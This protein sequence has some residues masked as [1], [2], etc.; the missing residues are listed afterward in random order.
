MD[1]ESLCQRAVAG[2]QEALGSLIMLHQSRLKRMIAVRIEPGLAARVD[3]SDVIQE[4]SL[5][6]ARRIEEYGN[7]QKVPF[8]VWM[9]FLAKQKLAEL[10]RRHVYAQSRDVRREVRLNPQVQ[11][12]SSRM[13]TEFLLADHTSPS[14]VLGNAEHKQLIS[15]T[16]DSLEP[17][18]R[19]IILMRHAEQLTTSEIAH[20]LNI[21][22]NNCRQRYLRALKHLKKI[23]TDLDINLLGG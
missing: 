6:A 10:V 18:D 5:E 22:E 15:S 14:S 13:L 23:L 7:L 17:I 4:V 12:S 11:D 1:E 2:H 20:E 16:I 19:E 8:F 9:R 3:A 21:T